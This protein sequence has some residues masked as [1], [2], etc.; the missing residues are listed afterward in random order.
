MEVSF[1]YIYV[2]AFIP[3]D[4]KGG[5]GE[6]HYL[7]RV[8]SH[9]SVP[10]FLPAPLGSAGEESRRKRESV[11]EKL[12]K[13]KKWQQPPTLRSVE[14]EYKGK[15]ERNGKKERDGR[16]CRPKKREKG[17][18]IE[19]SS[20]SAAGGSAGN[21]EK[22]KEEDEA[23]RKSVAAGQREKGR[24]A[25]AA[26]A[27]TAV[28]AS[29]A[30][31]SEKV[32]DKAS[33]RRVGSSARAVGSNNVNEHSSRSRCMLCIMVRAK[34]LMSALGDVISALATKS[35]HIPYRNSKLPHL[36]QDSLGGDSKT[37]MFLQISPSEQDLSETLSS[38]NFATRVR[39]VELGPAKKQIDTSE[40]QKMKLMLDKARQESR[41]KDESLRKVE[42]SIQNMENKAMGKD[43][44]CKTQQEKIKELEGQLE[45]KTTLHSQ[46]EK[47]LLHF[48]ERLKGREEICSSLQQKI[49]ELEN[50][51]REREL[52]E[53]ATYQQK[54]KVLKKQAERASARVQISFHHPPAKG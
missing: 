2:Y 19:R 13:K 7:L 48:S 36:L 29:A 54:A 26:A 17:R 45:S 44:L 8:F 43:R 47:Q 53:S 28:A 21:Q 35:S 39:G 31:P 9:C 16:S 33:F 23:G 11:R 42:E 25:A 27:A 34:N 41:S 32:R 14:K 12:K 37:L 5:G 15:K 18:E 51:L 30:E 20:N 24:D 1:L 49:K 10:I 38:L 22:E 40:L 3:H 50:K 6:T 46:Y 52:L 4:L